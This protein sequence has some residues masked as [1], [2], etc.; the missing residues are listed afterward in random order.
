MTELKT[1]LACVILAAGHG[2]RMKSSLPKVLHQVGHRPMLHH[3][4]ALGQ[5]L[6]AARQVVVVGAGG[7]AVAAAAKEFDD[8]AAIAVQDP[9][10]GTGHAVQ[11]ALPA[12][13]GFDGT[14]LI[15]YADTPLMR[16]ETAAALIG[17]VTEGAA[18]S[19]LG[20]ETDE[21][22]AYG[23]LITDDKGDLDRIVEF[24][25]ASEDE[26]A[27]TLCNAGLMAA[28]AALLRE[29]LPKL[30]N[31]NAQGEYYLTDLPA[32]AK[33]A[34]GR[35]A[36]VRAGIDETSGVNRRSE[37]AA[38]EAV[39]QDR[40]REEMMD[41]GVT[42][43]DPSSV[44][45]AHDTRI[46]QDVVIGPHVVF[47]PGVTI[48]EGVRIEAFSHLEGCT[49]QA[50]ASIGPYARLRPG[51][52][53]G[54]G[55]KIGNFVETKKAVLGPGAK[56]SHLTYLGDAQI[57]AE[58]NIGAGTITCNYDGYDKHLT[59]IGEGAFVGSNS[60]LVAPVT[61]GKGAYV[62][63]G[64]VVT[65]SVPDDAL[66]VARGRQMTKEDWAKSFRARKEP[67]E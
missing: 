41:A 7:E 56:V 53:V 39:F 22:G 51:T 19:V 38:A 26:R 44:W 59:V 2:S 60:S 52:D 27:V 67:K 58:A 23:R 31:D 16:A 1:E 6:G 17:T 13:E 25:D 64:S 35:C 55:A 48:G 34:G 40:R 57:G 12:L 8:K 21:P 36:I 37:L 28:P 5:T 3:V 15:L 65:K 45:F 66:T 54:A 33:A 10:Q 29:H 18:L 30:S 43:I 61:I 14:V 20:F 24:K 11:M 46:A 9:P 42:L 47:G 62:G 32:M 63:S 49:V 50:S 4:M